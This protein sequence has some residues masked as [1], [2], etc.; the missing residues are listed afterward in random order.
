MFL[1]SGE[2]DCFSPVWAPDGEKIYF[3]DGLFVQN[4]LEEDWS[5]DLYTV[6]VSSGEKEKILDGN[7]MA[8]DI[9]PDG[10]KLGLI[11]AYTHQILVLDLM[12][13]TADTIFKT[14]YRIGDIEFSKN[15]CKIFC[16]VLSKDSSGIWSIDIETQEMNWL[17]ESHFPVVSFDV[18]SDDS[19]WVI[20]CN[21]A[22]VNVKDSSVVKKLFVFPDLLWPQF[23]P[24]NIDI[25]VGVG[26]MACDLYGDTALTVITLA[27]SHRVAFDTRIKKEGFSTQP[28]WSPDGNRI[29][30]CAAE[31]VD[32][33]AGYM[34]NLSLWILKNA[35]NYIK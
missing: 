18:T 35:K 17:I 22:W 14:P 19:V 30:F 28:Y 9:S 3:L 15:G 2:Y 23:A 31:F 34:E 6:S 4:G 25:L 12:N 11:E 24:D 7:F 27:D 5:G 10:K 32:W 16:C 20:T 26:P 33:E 29:V 8:I 1:T 13:M 21:P